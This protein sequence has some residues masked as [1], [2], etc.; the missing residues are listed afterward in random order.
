MILAF[1]DRGRSLLALVGDGLEVE[2]LKVVAPC[3]PI[4]D[5]SVSVLDP[6]CFRCHQ[7]FSSLPVD[8]PSRLECLRLSEPGPWYFCQFIPVPSKLSSKL[9]HFVTLVER[10]DLQQTVVPFRSLSVMLTPGWSTGWVFSGTTG[11]LMAVVGLAAAGFWRQAPIWQ[12]LLRSHTLCSLLPEKGDASMRQQRQPSTIKATKTAVVT[13]PKWL[14]YD[15]GVRHWVIQ[16]PTVN[17]HFFSILFIN[18]LPDEMMQKRWQSEPL[19][20]ES[21]EVLPSSLIDY[22]LEFAAC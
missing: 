6:R 19:T 7:A 3:F 1:F 14:I 18:D 9:I 10:K 15:Q 13:D 2:G 17:L 22:L 5:L 12:W 20:P 4:I 11:P 16:L 21:D 8:V